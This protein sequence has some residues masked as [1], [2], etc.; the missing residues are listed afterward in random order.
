MRG[1]LSG[2]L[3]PKLS[4]GGV[5]RRVLER[6]IFALLERKSSAFPTATNTSK[7][8][9]VENCDLWHRTNMNGGSA[10]RHGSNTK[11][12]VLE[13]LAVIFRIPHSKR[14]Q[15]SNQVLPAVRP[16]K[17]IPINPDLWPTGPSP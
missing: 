14:I 10:A 4:V 2:F 11:V 6:A 9:S 5:F 1:E 8:R 7:E 16:I 12:R 3:N 15:K 13:A 17:K